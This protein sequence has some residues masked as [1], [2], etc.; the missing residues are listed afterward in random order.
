MWRL[1]ART[2]AKFRL[3]LRLV[4]IAHSLPAPG[5]IRECSET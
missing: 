1:L 2:L 4:Q 3:L 5:A